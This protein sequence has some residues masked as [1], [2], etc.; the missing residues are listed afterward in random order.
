MHKQH[1]RKIMDDIVAIIVT[2]KVKGKG[3][4]LTW[5]RIIEGNEGKDLALTIVGHAPT[6]GLVEPVKVVI[7][8]SLQEVSHYP[9]LHEG[10]FYFEQHPILFGATYKKWVA[11]RKRALLQGK[12]IFFIGCL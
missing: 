7:A 8:R 11:Q 3:A 6:F 12:G 10:L 2:D 1:E 5:G 4:F 9:L